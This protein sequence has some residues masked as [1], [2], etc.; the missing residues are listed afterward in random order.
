MGGQLSVAAI[1][2]PFDGSV[3]VHPPDGLRCLT[4]VDRPV[5]PFDLAV[6]LGML[7]LGE[8]VFDPVFFAPHVEHVSYVSGCRTVSVVRKEGELDAPLRLP[9]LQA[10][11]GG[12][13]PDV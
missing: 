3:L 9:A 4:L 5:H 8:P 10:V 1:M 13:F 11:E 7:D 2:I 6:R 12:L